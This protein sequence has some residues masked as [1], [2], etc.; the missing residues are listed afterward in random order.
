MMSDKYQRFADGSLKPAL[1][2]AEYDMLRDDD[3]FLYNRLDPQ[4]DQPD[5]AGCIMCCVSPFPHDC[6]YA[7]AAPKPEPMARST[8]NG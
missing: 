3:R 2:P 8:K 4:F 6:P 7:A 1:A 5:N